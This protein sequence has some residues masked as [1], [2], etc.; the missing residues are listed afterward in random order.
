MNL[1]TIKQKLL[2]IRTQNSQQDRLHIVDG[3]PIPVSHF[4]RARGCKRFKGEANYGYCASKDETYF[5][6]KGHIIVN[7]DGEISGLAMTPANTSE[8]EMMLPLSKNIRGLLLG[9][10]GYL[11]EGLKETLAAEDIILETPVRTPMCQP[12]NEQL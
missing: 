1:W 9:D 7:Y 4:K 3:F 8:R 2:D 10:K 6:F 12:A 5:V 11:G